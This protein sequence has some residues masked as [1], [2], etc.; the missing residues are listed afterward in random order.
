MTIGTGIAK[1]LVYKVE[2]TEG[3]APSAGSA[4]YLRR[5]TSD[6]KLEK[7][8]YSSDE[9]T[10]HRQVNDMRHGIKKA[11]GT[12]NGK[13]S[14]GSYKDFMAAILGQ[15][16]QSAAT[17]GAITTVT[18][19][20]SG[21]H[22]VRSSGS[23]LTAGFKVGD[24]IRWTGWDAAV[25]GNNNQNYLITA[26]TATDM[27]VTGASVSARASGDTV[28]G[29]VVGKKTFI[30]ASG[31]TDLSYSIEEWHSDVSLSHLY[32]GCKVGTIDIDMP[33]TGMTTIAVGFM[34]KGLT[35]AGSA[36]YTTPTAATTTGI[37]SAVT[38]T[39]LINGTAVATVTAAKIRINRNLTQAQVIGSNNIATTFTGKFD[40]TGEFTVYLE[41]GTYRDYFINEDE[42]SLVLRNDATTAA[43]SDSMVFVMPRLKINSWT[44]DDG[45][46]GHLQTFQFTALY[47]SSGGSGTS[48]EK[49]TLSVQDTTVS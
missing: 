15:A 33:T 13:L 27:T 11:S 32:T 45:D 37:L 23:F 40:V 12:L 43:A 6:F 5:V 49:T 19:A 38:G 35:T 48:S 36:Y 28:T 41:N 4:Q 26:L 16:W 30:P 8:T 3:T 31:H 29:V 24:L 47:N 20:A 44:V 9:L 39:V 25:S 18:A 34:G 7:E 46:K 17:T 1:L 22:F 10:E 42:I 21:P 2:S 14:C